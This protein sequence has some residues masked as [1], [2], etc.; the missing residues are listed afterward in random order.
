MLRSWG[1]LTSRMLSNQS[2]VLCVSLNNILGSCPGL[3]HQLKGWKCVSTTQ[4]A[5][6]R[7]TLGVRYCV[8]LKFAEK[9][10]ISSTFSQ[11]PPICSSDWVYC[12]FTVCSFGGYFSLKDTTAGTWPAFC[13]VTAEMALCCRTGLLNFNFIFP[14]W[15][16][17]LAA[18]R[19]LDEHTTLKHYIYV[20]TALMYVRR[21]PNRFLLSGSNN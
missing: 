18:K 21:G 14:Q 6:C 4:A 5:C 7:I 17:P 9:I 1:F 8:W 3:E 16:I 13:S 12:Q 2:C 15:E 19:N 10:Q 20:K 11:S